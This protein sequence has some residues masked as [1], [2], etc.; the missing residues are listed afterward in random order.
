MTEVEKP[1]P[2]ELL[3]R[4]TLYVSRVLHVPSYTLVIHLSLGLRAGLDV[5]SYLRPPLTLVR[6]YGG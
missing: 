4:C 1:L 5:S 2:G 3:R 6:T